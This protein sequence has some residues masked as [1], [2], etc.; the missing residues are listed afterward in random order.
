MRPHHLLQEEPTEPHPGLFPSLA[1]GQ[2]PVGLILELSDTDPNLP[3]ARRAMLM[4]LVHALERDVP[5]PSW[6]LA[7][8]FKQSHLGIFLGLDL[9]PWFPLPYT[10]HFLS[11]DQKTSHCPH[12]PRALGCSLP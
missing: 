11:L 12:S 4:R 5:H 1:R 2:H 6:F 10:F 9:P 7:Q 3:L 8:R